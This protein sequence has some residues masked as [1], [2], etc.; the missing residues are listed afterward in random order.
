MLDGNDGGQSVADIGAGEIRIL[1]F[2]DADLAGIA[3]HDRRKRRLEAGDM[4][5]A[6]RIVDIV[7]ETENI[8]MEFIDILESTFHGDIL[9][10]AGETDDTADGF[11]V[12][13]HVAD[14]AD[15]A[16]RFVERHLDRLC[17]PQVLKIYRKLRIQVGRLV[18]PAD[19]V[20]FLEIR[21]VENLT[22]RQESDLRTG[23]ARLADDR[24]QAFLELYNRLATVVAVM[25][26]AP[27]PADLHIEPLGERV[28]NR[29]AHAVQTAACLVGT[30]VE[31]AAGMQGRE[32]ETLGGNAFLVQVGRDAL[33]RLT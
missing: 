21:A 23:L 26:D 31:L 3:V 16:V 5:A 14:V 15:E 2:E 18:Q 28:D 8:F 11:L 33:F 30:A 20:V 29:A 7:A 27:A 13:I 24:Q 4:R 1:L 19:H 17:A 32:N 22:V 25:I 6:F 9:A 12:G 10:D